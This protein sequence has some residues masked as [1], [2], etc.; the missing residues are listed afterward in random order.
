MMCSMATLVFTIAVTCCC[1]NLMRQFPTNYIILGVF[2]VGVSFIVSYA[3]LSYST[4]AVAQAVLATGFIFG[5]LTAYACLTK[6]DFTGLGPYLHGAL[7]CLICFP[8]TLW[9]FS[10]FGL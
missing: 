3:T 10:L 9:L 5:G 8:M 7:L 2:T 6:T 4:Q 1:S